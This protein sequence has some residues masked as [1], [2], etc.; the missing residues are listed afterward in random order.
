M[1][2]RA[3]ESKGETMRSSRRVAISDGTQSPLPRPNRDRGALQVLLFAIISKKMDAST[4]EYSQRPRV[5]GLLV[6]L[7]LPIDLSLGVTVRLA[8]LPG[9]LVSP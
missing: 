6:L 5:A 4:I 9:V 3:L 2:G 8:Q 7:T 1:D